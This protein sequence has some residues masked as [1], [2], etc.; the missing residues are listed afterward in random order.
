MG[1]GA[2]ASGGGSICA[3]RSKSSVAS[4]AL[5]SPGALCEDDGVLVVFTVR[6]YRTVTLDF[7]I[8]YGSLTSH[9]LA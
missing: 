9:D 2:V 8:Y 7:A 6:E 3:S 1:R 5:H 4:F